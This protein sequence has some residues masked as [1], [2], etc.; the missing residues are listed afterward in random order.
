M[1]RL[2]ILAL[3]LALVLVLAALSLGLLYQSGFTLGN[4]ILVVPSLFFLA[5]IAFGV[6]GALRRPPRDGL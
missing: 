4:L 6:V 1:A 3:A 2:A 5:L